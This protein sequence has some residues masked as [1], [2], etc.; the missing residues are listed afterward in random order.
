[1]IKDRKSCKLA[2]ASLTLVLLLIP[3]MWILGHRGNNTLLFFMTLFALFKAF[4]R[5]FAQKVDT[6]ILGLAH[7]RGRLIR[8][9]LSLILLALSLA[10]I[11]LINHEDIRFWD[12][13]RERGLGTLVAG[14][15]LGFNVL[16]TLACRRHSEKKHRWKWLLVTL[17]FAGLTFDELN[18]IH[19]WLPN[20]LWRQAGGQGELIIDGAVLWITIMAPVALAIIIGLIWF[21][22]F[23]LSRKARFT[24]LAA[25]VCWCL[26]LVLEA[27]TESHILP[28]VLE[29]GLEEFFE[30]LGSILFMFAFLRELGQLHPDPRPSE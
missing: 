27:T 18:E 9:V 10:V 4:N 5:P 7:N 1:M 2:L 3:V 12:L 23:V 26:V 25:L 30:M 19:G 6:I 14:V 21:L 15:L 8:F 11:H 16:A 13:N 20:Y 29:V 22:F 28:W 17:L 24:A